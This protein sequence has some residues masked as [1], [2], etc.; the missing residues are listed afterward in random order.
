MVPCILLIKKLPPS[1]PVTESVQTC[2]SSKV[3]TRFPVKHF[4]TCCCKTKPKKKE[5]KKEK[6]LPFS[7]VS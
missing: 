5:K 4:H 7:K 3:R 2:F 6:A 1:S